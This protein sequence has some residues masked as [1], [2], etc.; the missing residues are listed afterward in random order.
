MISAAPKF[1]GEGVFDFWESAIKSHMHTSGVEE[2]DQLEVAKLCVQGD[3]MEYLHSCG[4][5]MAE[6]EDLF[7]CLRLRYGVS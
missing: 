6:L 2:D 7:E 5:S 1:T 3:A 4:Q